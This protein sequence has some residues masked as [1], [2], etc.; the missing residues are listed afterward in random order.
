MHP[1]LP[2]FFFALEILYHTKKW[3]PMNWSKIQNVTKCCTDI[4]MFYGSNERVKPNFLW[5]NICLN[6]SYQCWRQCHPLECCCTLADNDRNA[7]EPKCNSVWWW[8]WV[9]YASAVKLEYFAV[10]IDVSN[11]KLTQ[12]Y[13]YYE[14]FFQVSI[15]SVW[16][17][18]WLLVFPLYTHIHR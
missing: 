5:T 17:A 12:V 3:L 6:E 1:F 4:L 8:V 15:C 10:I 9:C 14:F 7:R 11:S 18:D 16:Q 2:R 13:A